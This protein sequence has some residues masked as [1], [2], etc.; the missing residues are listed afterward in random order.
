MVPSPNTPRRTSFRIAVV[1][2]GDVLADAG[3]PGH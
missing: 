1:S 2:I 3:W